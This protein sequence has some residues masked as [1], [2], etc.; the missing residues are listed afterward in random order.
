MAAPRDLRVSRFSRVTAL[1]Y[2]PDS[3]AGAMTTGAVDV[4]AVAVRMSDA[5]PA[6]SRAIVSAVDGAIT[7]ASAAA[8][9]A[10]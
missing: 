8:P 4:S 5:I 6:A 7:T 2:I 3:I 1:R 10:T 9:S